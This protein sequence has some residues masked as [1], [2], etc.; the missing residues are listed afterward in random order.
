MVPGQHIAAIARQADDF[1]V[2]TVTD[3]VVTIR[4][5]KSQSKAAMGKE[6]F[7][8]SKRAVLDYAASLI[9]STREEAVQQAGQAA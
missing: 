5:A 2:V 4:Q 8:A 9:G 1:A 7:A 3:R 6:T